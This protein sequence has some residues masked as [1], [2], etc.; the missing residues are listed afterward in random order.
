MYSNIGGKIKV[1]AIVLFVIEAVLSVFSAFGMVIFAIGEGELGM[2]LLSFLICFLGPVIA[3]VASWVLYGFGELIAK[4]TDIANNTRGEA[5]KS[6][7]QIKHDTSRI[8][9]IENL[10]AQGL[11]TEAEYQQAIAKY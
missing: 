9:V 10:R 6:Q 1:L 4:A 7:T 5:K 3:W 8:E 2:F 11:I